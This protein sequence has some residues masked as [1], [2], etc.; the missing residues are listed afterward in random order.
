MA[1]IALTSSGIAL[2]TAICGS[3]SASEKSL[4]ISKVDLESNSN[5]LK[6]ICSVN[7]GIILSLVIIKRIS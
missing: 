2:L 7:I 6:L 1:S 4:T 3:L 5:E